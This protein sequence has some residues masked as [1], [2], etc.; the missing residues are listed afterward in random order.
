MTSSTV[1]NEWV[2]HSAGNPHIS[3]PFL[4][5]GGL[6]P[7]FWRGNQASE[8]Q[9][10]SEMDLTSSALG[11]LSSTLLCLFH[12]PLHS[13]FQQSVSCCLCWPLTHATLSQSFELPRAGN[14]GYLESTGFEW[15]PGKRGL[16]ECKLV[17]TP[18]EAVWRIL[19]KL[20]IELPYDPAIPAPQH[21]SGQD[22][23]SKRY[24]HLYVHGS[25][26]HNSQ[27]ME[28]T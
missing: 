13:W 3:C 22:C 9:A 7:D 16:S 18:W 14:P 26:I 4:P 19:R 23:N 10:A 27:D 28:T 24:M 2:R 8:W 20:N 11:E 5:M 15:R 6:R 1:R 17:W 25:T 12:P 21:I